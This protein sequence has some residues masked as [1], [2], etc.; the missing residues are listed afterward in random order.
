MAVTDPFGDLIS[1]GSYPFVVGRTELILVPRS[2][3]GVFTPVVGNRYPVSRI[4]RAATSFTAP[5]WRWAYWI[6]A[7]DHGAVVGT[8]YATIETEYAKL[9]NLY[10]TTNGDGSGG[11]WQTLTISK[12]NGG[13]VS[14]QAMLVDFPI[15]AINYSHIRLE[16]V[17]HLEANLV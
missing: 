14:A 6:L 1:F 17:F 8:E 5:E 3:A 10:D 2:T 9:T 11:M 15:R 7:S 4:G 13:N 12:A 16:L